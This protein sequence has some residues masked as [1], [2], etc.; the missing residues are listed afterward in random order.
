MLP[1]ISFL[2]SQTAEEVAVKR[3]LFVGGDTTTYHWNFLIFL[4]LVGS[5]FRLV[6]DLLLGLFLN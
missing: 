2:A 4:V 1:C 6:L 5:S 3:Y